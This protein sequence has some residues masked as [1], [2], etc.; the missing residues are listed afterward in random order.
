MQ[1]RKI[2]RL[3]CLVLALLTACSQGINWR[4]VTVKDT[5]LQ[6]WLPCKPVDVSK[7]IPLGSDPELG[8]VKVTMVGCEKDGQQFTVSYISTQLNEG[9]TKSTPKGSKPQLKSL[10]TQEWQ[11][12][13][14][15]GSLSSI[16]YDP[17]VALQ[18]WT[19]IKGNLNPSAKYTQ[20]NGTRGVN[21]QF[22]WFGYE[23][24]IFQ[25]AY[26]KSSE[27]KE[28][29]S[30]QEMAETFLTSAKLIGI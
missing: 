6:I 15:R 17:Q 16:G 3:L 9:E 12:M 22:V 25:L 1:M 18:E 13:L 27:S 5:G 30:E 10:T 20:V 14:Q 21:A 2:C 19:K 26:Y 24:T 7:N 8:Q 11:A 4:E 29:A 23:N 28:T